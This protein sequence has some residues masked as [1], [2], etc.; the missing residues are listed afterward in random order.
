MTARRGKTARRARGGDA[1]SPSPPSSS[2]PPPPP[3]LP[4]LPPV[5]APWAD[6]MRLDRPVGWVL[7]LVPGWCALALAGAANARLLSLFLLGAIL[8]RAAGC[9]ANDLADRRIDG[10]VARTAGRPLVVGTV[11]AR[12]ALILLA[13]LLCASLGVLLALPMPAWFVG[14]AALPLVAVY[15]YMKRFTGWPQAMLGITYAW[16]ALLGWS[17][18]GESLFAATPW[19]LYA[20]AVFWTVGY[21]T[22]YAAADIEDDTRLRIGSSARSLGGRLRTAVGLCF[23]LTCVL[24]AAAL[25]AAGFTPLGLGSSALFAWFGLGIL[26]LSFARQVRRM[27]KDATP[28][29]AEAL[30]EFKAHSRFGL[31]WFASLYAAMHFA[32]F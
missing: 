1:P 30:L 14:A 25:V 10:G 29:P 31:V 9:V 19:L 17:A 21:D 8:M 4:P 15:P 27:P 6:L 5:L 11:S 7:L 24:W 23:A 20:G 28:A 22:L 32:S 16:G 2:S 26:A 18:S 12:G 3:P 13:A